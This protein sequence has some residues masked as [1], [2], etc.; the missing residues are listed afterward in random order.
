[1]FSTNALIDG[2][3][4]LRTIYVGIYY[5]SVNKNDGVLKGKKKRQTLKHVFVSWILKKF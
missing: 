3:L 2:F 4:R 1:M 5:M